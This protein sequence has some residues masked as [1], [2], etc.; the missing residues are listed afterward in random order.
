MKL[1]AE[2]EDKESHIASLKLMEKLRIKSN[3]KIAHPG[4]DMK[5]DADIEVPGTGPEN[6]IAPEGTRNDL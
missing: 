6:A 2:A 1:E 3:N 4:E 5:R